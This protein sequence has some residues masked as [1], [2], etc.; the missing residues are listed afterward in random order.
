MGTGYPRVLG[1]RVPES[2][3]GGTVPWS[4]SL[5]EFSTRW[6]PGTMQGFAIRGGSNSD[7]GKSTFIGKANKS[8]G[9]FSVPRR[10]SENPSSRSSTK[11]NKLVPGHEYPSRNSYISYK[12]QRLWDVVFPSDVDAMGRVQGSAARICCYKNRRI[13][14]STVLS[15]EVR[16]DPR[17]VGIPT[18]VPG[19]PVPGYTGTEQA[20]FFDEFKKI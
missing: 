7:G 18:Q 14:V 1:Y 2:P 8:G 5:L 19:Y 6:Y 17:F 16:F 4:S 20:H 3:T 10:L 9:V 12:H 11:G 13:A 15:S